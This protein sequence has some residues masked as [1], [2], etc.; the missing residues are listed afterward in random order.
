LNTTPT[1]IAGLSEIAG[2][3]DALICDVWGVLHDGCRTFPAACD[4]L[5]KFREA[6][7]RV[8]LLTNAPRPP[9]D[10]MRQ[11]Q[12]LGMPEGCVDAIV[13]SGGASR[14]DIA[15]RAATAKVTGSKV[16]LMHIGPERDMPIYLG[17]DVALC[18]PDEADVV[19]LSGLDDHDT[20]TP[21]M[22]RERLERILAHD[23]TVICANPDILVPINGKN[24]YCAG[25][26]AKLYE[27]MGG[28]VI[29]YGKPKPP[30]YRMAL[31]A[32]QSQKRVLAVGDALETDIEGAHLAGLDVLF[33][34]GG[35][36]AA[37]VGVLTKESLAA[38]FANK[39]TSVVAGIDLLGW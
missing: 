15:A 25:A 30:I 23:L 14:D 39:Q 27:D 2:E 37:E 19:L 7:G 28:K 24:V 36:H 31:A 35:L 3:Y 38:F 22:Y 9:A 17:L 10:V 29:Y 20:D 18:G 8:V 5:K 16:K 13:S 6:C 11:L 1:C 26:V 34:A 4:A 21:E 12:G 33:V 32:A